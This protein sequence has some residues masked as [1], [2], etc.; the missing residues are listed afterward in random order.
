LCYHAIACTTPL[1]IIIDKNLKMK[2]NLTI[3]T[4]ASIKTDKSLCTREHGER[5]SQSD[6]GA[7][8]LIRNSSL[9]KEL[10]REF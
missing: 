6:S 4:M 9:S 1:S 8:L 5:G 10:T 3:M 2:T 7:W